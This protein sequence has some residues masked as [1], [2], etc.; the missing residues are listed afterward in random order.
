ME[1]PQVFIVL[2][3]MLVPI[4]IVGFITFGELVPVTDRLVARPER[5]SFKSELNELGHDSTRQLL[6][7]EGRSAPARG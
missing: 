4:S 2:A 1:W 3:V 7:E 6:L 5:G